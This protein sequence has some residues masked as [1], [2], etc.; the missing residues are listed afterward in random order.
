MNIAVIFAGG[1]GTRMNSKDKPKQFLKMHDKPIIIHTLEKF[2]NN[3]NI[4]AIVIACIKQWINHLL[5]LI[6][7][8]HISKVKRIVP[9]G[10][11]GQLSIYAG[12]NAAKDIA[13]GK[14]A[15]VLIHDGVRPLIN[16]DVINKNIASV[17]KNGSAITSVNV[18]ETIMEINDDASIKYIPDRTHSRLARAPQSFL[19]DEILDV[20]NK[21][22]LEGKKDFIDSCTMMSHYGK[23]LYLIDGPIE[24]IKVTTPQDFYIM[25]AILDAQEN[26]QIYGLE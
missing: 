13:E 10:E 12:L 20:H 2:Q 18:T 26:S 22:L 17:M 1:T 23:K 5:Q 21:A 9:G 15:I 14:N 6:E 25:R 7:Y 19:L 8:Y 4:D 16:D 3:E 11:T 24:N